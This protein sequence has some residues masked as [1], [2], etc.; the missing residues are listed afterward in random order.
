L[1]YNVLVI[2]NGLAKGFNWKEISEDNG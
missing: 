2:N 1:K